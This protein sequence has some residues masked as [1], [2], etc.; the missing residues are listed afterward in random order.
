MQNEPHDVRTAVE[1]VVAAYGDLSNWGRWGEDD[2]LGTAQLA[3]P[4]SIL[5]AA[6]SIRHGQVFPLG[7]PVDNAGF[8]L[9]WSPEIPRTNPIHIMTKTGLDDGDRPGPHFAEDAIFMPLQAGTQWDALGHVHADGL[10][11]NGHDAAQI[12]VRGVGA[13]SID[14][15]ASRL[16]GRGVL[17]D[18]ARAQGVDVLAAA[19]P[20]NAQQLRDTVSAHG[21]NVRPGDHVLIRTGWLGRA[22]AGDL[23]VAEFRAS[24]PGLDLDALRWL[25]EA[26]ASAVAADNFGVEVIPSTDPDLYYPVHHIGIQQMGLTFGEFFVLDELAEDCAADG[27][28]DFFFSGAPLPVTAGAGSPVNPIAVR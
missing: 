27:V 3:D 4:A 21:V 20:I 5:A 25:S 15:L 23:T 16:V 9:L 28:Y 17:L 26:G 18:V 10:M 19:H 14:Q 7:L 6:A 24:E 2:Q 1:E 11:Y 12:T 8:Q 22:L 13:N